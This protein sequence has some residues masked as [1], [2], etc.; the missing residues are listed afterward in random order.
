MRVL[1]VEDHVRLASLMRR[2]MR[3]RG[4]LADVAIRGEDALWMAGSI[5]YDV[6]SLDVALPGM[7]G[8]ETCR[9]LR[10]D[11]VTTPIV[12]LTA[13]DAVDYR[14]AGLDTGADDYVTKPFD[15]AELLARMRA[16]SRRAARPRPPVLRVGDLELDLGTCE[17]RRGDRGIQLT[18]RERELLAVLMSRAGEAVSR[19][20]LLD[21]AWADAAESVRSN[22]LDVYVRYLRDKVDRPFGLQTI[23][24]VRGVGYRLSAA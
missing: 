14:V 11:G 18:A 1:I 20:E 22:V 15:L 21:G 6:I 23:E 12:M 5:D 24:T 3:A 17:A 8:F 4:V 2:A 10:A 9:R 7:D 13:R 19:A 16:L